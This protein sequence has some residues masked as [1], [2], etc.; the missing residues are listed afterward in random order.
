[1]QAK[2]D[3]DFSNLNL[4]KIDLS[5]LGGKLSIIWETKLIPLI[6]ISSILLLSLL[7]RIDLFFKP[8][9]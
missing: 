6:F 3:L 1:M 7:E 9:K 5:S 8:S 2:I 4:S